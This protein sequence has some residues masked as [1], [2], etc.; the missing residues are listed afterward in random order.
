M[1]VRRPEAKLLVEAAAPLLEDG[2]EAGAVAVLLEGVQQSS[3]EAAAPSSPPR[4]R[5]SSASTSGL[6]KM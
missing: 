3:Q 1:S 4:S 2:V 5:P 6:T